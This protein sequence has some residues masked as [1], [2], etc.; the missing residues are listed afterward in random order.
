[1]DDLVNRI[2]ELTER[3]KALPKPADPEMVARLSAAIDALA[4]AISAKE[5]S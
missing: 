3:V 4:D 5:A 2:N 1:M